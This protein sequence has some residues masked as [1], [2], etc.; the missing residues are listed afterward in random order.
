MNINATLGAQVLNFF[1]AYL[2]F[3]F[4]LLKPAYIAIQE[5]EENRALL[6]KLIVDDKQTIEAYRFDIDRQ[7]QESALFFKRYYPKP[8]DT[9]TLFKDVIPSLSFKE[10]SISE[11]AVATMRDQLK[12]A[13]IKSMGVSPDDSN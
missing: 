6:E 8:I 2:L 11:S 1:I 3:R 9:V 7:W 5:D 10:K 13:I 12:Q 4:I